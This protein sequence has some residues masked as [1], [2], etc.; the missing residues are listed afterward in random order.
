MLVI[1][2]NIWLYVATATEYP[3]EIYSEEL[4]RIISFYDDFSVETGPP[5]SETIVSAYIASEVADNIGASKP[6]KQ[7]PKSVKSLLENLLE[8]WWTAPRITADF[9]PDEIGELC[10][11]TERRDSKN[12]LLATLLDIQVKD[13]PIFM[14][15]YE[16]PEPV[17]L[18]TND[19]EFASFDPREFDLFGV[20]I[21]E[22]DL[23]WDLK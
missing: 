7:H 5:R 10:L 23:N 11:N 13:V 3:V 20:T 22:I 18:L 9:S 17:T 6:A 21:D 15:A 8:V 2:T 12:E 14:L 19:R 4:S 16:R 1:D